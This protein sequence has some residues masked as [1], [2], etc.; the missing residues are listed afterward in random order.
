M[1]RLLTQTE[2][3]EYL[4]LSPRSLE[5]WRVEG[6]GPRYSK[7]GKRIVYLARDLEQWVADRVR[8]STSE[9]TVV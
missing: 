7:L 9:T 1:E 6:I 8:N 5:R 3:A 4:R 2:A